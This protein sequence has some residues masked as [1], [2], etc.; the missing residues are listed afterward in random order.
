V[1]GGTR[2]G[3]PNS[4]ELDVRETALGTLI[5][6]KRR[7]P[8]PGGTSV[9]EVT[10]D[11]AFLMS[12]LVH[13]S[14]TAL[15]TEAL[16]RCPGNG[17]EVLVGGL[18]LGY[19]AE[20]AR[21]HPGVL[22]VRVIEILPEVLDWH[23]RGLVPLG[24][25]L[26][27]DP[28]CVLEKGDFFATLRAPPAPGATGWHAI[29][30]DIDHSPRAVLRA[31]HA[32]FYEETRLR[33]ASRHLVPGGVFALWS[34]DAPDARFVTACEGVFRDVEVRTIGFFNPW[35]DGDEINTIYLGRR[36]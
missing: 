24:D 8:G 10:L 34:A 11:G 16:A 2:E 27:S 6:R 31:D 21:T 13:A 4:A 30:V 28:R 29:L 15:A 18:G 32:G 7:L 12:S 1:T 9:T 17:W 25:V 19:T 14:E 33:E 26:A 3:G 5:L 23:R 35:I 20:A 22:H 36:R